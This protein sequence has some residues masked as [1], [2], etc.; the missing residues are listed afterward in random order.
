MNTT[1]N[2]L[3]A[4]AMTGALAAIPLSARAAQLTP[5][6]GPSADKLG[7]QGM[8]GQSG[9]KHSCKGKNLPAPQVD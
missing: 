4:A 2:L 5:M 3:I 9:D 8:A 7:C 6:S 1:K